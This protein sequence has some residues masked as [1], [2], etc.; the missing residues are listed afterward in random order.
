MATIDGG[1]MTSEMADFCNNRKTT[2]RSYKFYIILNGKYMAST[3]ITF[4]FSLKTT[5]YCSF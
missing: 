5:E 4:Q 1:M 3:C 2:L